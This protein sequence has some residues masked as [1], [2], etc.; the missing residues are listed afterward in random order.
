MLRFRNL[1]QDALGILRVFHGVDFPT[2]LFGR[3]CEKGGLAKWLGYMDKYI[4]FPVASLAQLSGIKR[5]FR[6]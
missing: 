1:V 2:R 5:K 4:L 3:P 6:M